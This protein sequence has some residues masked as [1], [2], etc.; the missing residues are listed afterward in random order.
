MTMCKRLTRKQAI[1]ANC[2]DCVYDPANSG[3][4]RQQVTLC[5]VRE[6]FLWPW[7]PVSRSD[8]PEHLLD[9]YSVS[10]AEKPV[11]RGPNRDF[12]ATGRK[13]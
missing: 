11:F 3:N 9:A 2:R 8:I 5:A 13:S 10:D 7:R 6:C 1:E 12:F 4:W